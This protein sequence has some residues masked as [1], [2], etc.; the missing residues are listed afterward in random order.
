MQSDNN[1]VS[2]R[3]FR[4]PCFLPNQFTHRSFTRWPIKDEELGLQARTTYLAPISDSSAHPPRHHQYRAARFMRQT[5]QTP[6]AQP[7]NTSALLGLAARMCCSE[8]R[9]AHPDRQNKVFLDPTW[10]Q[11]PAL[12]RY[13]QAYLAWRKELNNL[14]HQFKPAHPGCCACA[15]FVHF[16]A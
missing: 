8:F 4:L 12:Q 5:I 11:K 6:V 13:M 14:D 3:R 15:N 7:P 2:R 1:S 10:T 16:A 9:D